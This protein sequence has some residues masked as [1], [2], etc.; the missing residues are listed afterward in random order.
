MAIHLNKGIRMKNGTW[1]N[2]FSFQ[3]LKTNQQVRVVKTRQ[4][5]SKKMD[6]LSGICNKILQKPL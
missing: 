5:L 1:K 2:V 3:S 6:T 4:S